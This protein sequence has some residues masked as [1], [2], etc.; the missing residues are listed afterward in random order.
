M[1]KFIL[2][3]QVF[4]GV[5][6]T[7]DTLVDLGDEDGELAAR[8][9]RRR[10]RQDSRGDGRQPGGRSADSGVCVTAGAEITRRP[11]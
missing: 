10:D 5:Q 9:A 2:K 7:E 1:P 6:M 3:P 8:R 4:D 11:Q